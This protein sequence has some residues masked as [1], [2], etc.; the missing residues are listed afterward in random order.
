MVIPLNTVIFIS[1]I[2]VW[3]IKVC[4]NFVYLC[5]GMHL[6]VQ[7]QCGPEGGIESPKT[8]F[9]ELQLKVTGNKPM[10]SQEE[11][12]L[13]TPESPLQSLKQKL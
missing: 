12:V 3:F 7:Y 2:Y 13:L 6:W 11:Q 1:H 5:M 4:F 9:A 8:G 10:S